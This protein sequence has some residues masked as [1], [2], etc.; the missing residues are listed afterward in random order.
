MQNAA[1]GK[2]TW[3]EV[4]CVLAVLAALKFGGPAVTR[5]YLQQIP[6]PQGWIID[7]PTPRLEIPKF[8]LGPELQ[9]ALDSPPPSLEQPT[10][11]NPWR[12][13]SDFAPATGTVKQAVR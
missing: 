5:W 10:P 8:E 3:A 1:K 11:P 7:G 12:F 6:A 13:T 4:L 9:K 2:K